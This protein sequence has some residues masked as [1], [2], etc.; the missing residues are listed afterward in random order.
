[1]VSILLFLLDILNPQ[2]GVEGLPH[3]K[4]DDGRQKILNNDT[5]MSVFPAL[6]DSWK[7]LLKRE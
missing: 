7:T 2:G 3:K 6:F 1:M 4:V 5:N